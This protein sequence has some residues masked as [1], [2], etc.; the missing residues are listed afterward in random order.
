M[1]DAQRLEERNVH[2]PVW[3]KLTKE[4]E[5]TYIEFLNKSGLEPHPAEKDA[6]GYSMFSLFQLMLIFGSKCHA[7]EEDQFDYVLRFSDPNS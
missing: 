2:Q 3:V 7:D 6:L 4:G 5:I 1:A